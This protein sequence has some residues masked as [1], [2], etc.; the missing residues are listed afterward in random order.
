M[1]SRARSSAGPSLPAARKSVAL[2][3][4]GFPGRAADPDQVGDEPAVRL[5]VD[6]QKGEI[7]L[8][9]AARAVEPGHRRHDDPRTVRPVMQADPDLVAARPGAQH[10]PL[11]SL[12]R[13]S[14]AGRRC[15]NAAADPVDE[16]DMHL[17]HRVLEACSQL[18]GTSWVWFS[19]SPSSDRAGR[20]GRAAAPPRRNRRRRRRDAPRRIGP[21]PD[22]A[23]EPGLLGRLL[24]ALPGAVEF[25][26]V[27]DAADIVALDP[28]RSRK[29]IHHP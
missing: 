25:P 20:S 29:T 13:R 9:P 22:L 6:R 11:L 19:I 1:T 15:R 3:E 10:A 24:V 27:I 8:A 7:Q 17:V 12:R 16:G 18:H 14:A 23:G 4:V 21:D 2:G 26:A 5:V 28:A